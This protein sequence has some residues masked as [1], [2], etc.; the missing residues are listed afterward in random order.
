MV[1]SSWPQ[2][3]CSYTEKTDFLLKTV[4]HQQQLLNSLLKV[5]RINL[6]AKTEV[7][8][9]EIDNSKRNNTNCEHIP[10]LLEQMKVDRE[11]NNKRIDIMWKD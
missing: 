2:G 5:N 6:V 4:K 9:R 3:C 11:A 10:I 1:G 7:G 8:E